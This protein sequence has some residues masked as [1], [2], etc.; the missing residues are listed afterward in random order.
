MDHAVSTLFSVL[1]VLFGSSTSVCD[2]EEALLSA[3]LYSSA[4]QA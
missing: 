1:V 4:T 2:L 3:F